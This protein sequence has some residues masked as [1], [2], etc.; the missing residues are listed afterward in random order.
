MKGEEWGNLDN[1]MDRKDKQF[2]R[3]I[4]AVKRSRAEDDPID[5]IIHDRITGVDVADIV[6]RRS[7]YLRPKGFNMDEF[8]DSMS[9]F[10]KQAYG[11][12][13]SSKNNQSHMEPLLKISVSN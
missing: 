1:L 8:I 11:G 7:N 10:E 3:I 12:D 13:A 4:D 9:N 2:T 5:A 6:M